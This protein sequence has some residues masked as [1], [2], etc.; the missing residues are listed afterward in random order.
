MSR[1]LTPRSYTPP[2][3]PIADQSPGP[4]GV[5]PDAA[6]GLALVKPSVRAQTAY[7]LSSPPARRKLNQNE[8]PYDLPAELKAE[9]L[10][11]I[12]AA[13]WQRYPEFA[14]PAL[15]ERLAEHYGWRADGTLVGNGS[16]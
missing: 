10:A 2:A 5:P 6:E 13:P 11:E 1:P 12:S 4:A 3:R 8:S 16:N 15:L 14:P 9:V 7:A